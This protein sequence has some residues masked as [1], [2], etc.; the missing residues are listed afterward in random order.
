MATK[1]FHIVLGIFLV[2]V[3][4][5][6]Y[7]VFIM[8]FTGFVFGI[9]NELFRQVESWLIFVLAVVTSCILIFRIW[10]RTKDVA[11]ENKSTR[12]D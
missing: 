3:F 9:K 2:G 5:V 8:F 1:I 4:N 11:E 10:P 12:P 6:V 7:S